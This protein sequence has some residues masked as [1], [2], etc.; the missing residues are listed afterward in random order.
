MFE[1]GAIAMVHGSKFAPAH[2]PTD[3]ARWFTSRVEYSVTYQSEYEP[4]ILARKDMPAFDERFNGYGQGVDELGVVR[5]RDKRALYPHAP[6]PS[7]ELRP[8]TPR[9]WVR[10]CWMR[11]SCADFMAEMPSHDTPTRRTPPKSCLPWT[12]T[13]GGQVDRV[14]D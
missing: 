1:S 3:Y 9:W 7:Q 11:R 8:S 14:T 10:A 2:A 12:S 5:G 13:A 6:H 4:Y